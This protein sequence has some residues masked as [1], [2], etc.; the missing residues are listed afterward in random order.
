MP[1]AV[2]GRGR[3]EFGTPM[4]NIVCN[5]DGE[6]EENLKLFEDFVTVAL[7]EAIEAEYGGRVDDQVRS[8]FDEAGGL[9]S[10]RT[11]CG[12]SADRPWR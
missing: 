7:R 4:V 8:H 2:H 10:G 1:S 11:L 3:E 9:S 6:Y 5:R 12:R